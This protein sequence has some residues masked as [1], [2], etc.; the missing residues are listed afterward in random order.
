MSLTVEYKSATHEGLGVVVG[1]CMGV[2]YA[3]DGMIGSR[4]PEWIQG[5]INV[6]I[7]VFIRVGLMENIAKYKTMNYQT[8]VI[9]M[10]ISEGGFIQRSKGYGATYH[11]CIRRRI[12]FLDYGAEL[13]FVSMTDHRKQLYGVEP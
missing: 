7:G 2:F 6:L 10:G 13:T 4:N 12:P 11:E 8:G 9:H 3:D 5:D 1:Q